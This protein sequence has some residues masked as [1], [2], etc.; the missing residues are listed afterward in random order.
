MWRVCCT[1]LAL[2]FVTILCGFSEKDLA[3]YSRLFRLQF[4]TKTLP[5][6]GL[7]EIILTVPVETLCF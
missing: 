5:C 2:M 4:T 6:L 1:N 3:L 7:I